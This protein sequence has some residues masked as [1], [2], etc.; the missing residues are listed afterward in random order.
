MAKLPDARRDEDE[1]G[2]LVIVAFLQV[3]AFASVWFM[4]GIYVGRPVHSLVLDTFCGVG[5]L[6]ALLAAYASLSRRLN[7][8]EQQISGGCGAYEADRSSAFG[9]DNE[10]F[11]PSHVP[12]S[13]S[14]A[15]I[16]R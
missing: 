11:D 3:I 4:S 16:L 8:L 15:P 14:K 10:R 5:F 12:S 13:S 2:D 9:F 7:R 6:I 1:Q